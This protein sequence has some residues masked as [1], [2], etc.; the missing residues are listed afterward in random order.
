MADFS[1]LTVIVACFNE[2]ANIAECLQAFVKALPGAE[3][4]VVWGGNDKTGEITKEFSKAHPQVRLIVNVD[5]RGKGHAT[6][7]G[8]AAGTRPLQAQLDGDGQ[9][10]PEDLGPMVELLRSGKAD[11]VLGSRFMAG[12]RREPGSTPFFRTMGNHTISA[13][14]SLLF[15]HRMTDVQAGIKAW[16]KSALVDIGLISDDYS[17]EVEI[18]TRGVAR[19][20]RVADS[21]VATL[22]RFGGISHVNVVVDGLKLIWDVSLFRVRSLFE[23]RTPGAPASR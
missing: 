4:L 11:I 19:G 12:S 13:W 18:G 22:K 6:K 14:A 20:Y 15:F 21:P 10:L 16:R 3:L 1:D 9:F 7:T 8:I 17:Y 2:E 23:P 5:D